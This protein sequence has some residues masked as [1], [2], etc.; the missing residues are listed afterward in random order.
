MCVIRCFT[1]VYASSRNISV[2]WSPPL[3]APQPGLRVGEKR[4]SAGHFKTTPSTTLDAAD[5]HWWLI[6]TRHRVCLEKSGGWQV[7]A[8][9]RWCSG[10]LRSIHNKVSVVVTGPAFWAFKICVTAAL[11]LCV[12]FFLNGLIREFSLSENRRFINSVNIS[13]GLCHRE[14][15]TAFCTP[16]DCL[17]FCIRAVNY[18][19]QARLDFPFWCSKN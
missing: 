16:T 3:S 11:L 1:L 19:I 4:V 12:F 2:T 17:L 8:V 18:Q 7:E 15:A 13:T 6:L 5:K 10:S 14:T 9:H